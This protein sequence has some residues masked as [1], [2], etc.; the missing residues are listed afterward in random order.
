LKDSRNILPRQHRADVAGEACH[1]SR[2]RDFHRLDGVALQHLHHF[3]LEAADAILRGTNPG[4]IRMGPA[5][6]R[7]WV[8]SVDLA[9]GCKLPVCP[10]EPTCS[11]TASTEAMGQKATLFDHFVSADE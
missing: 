2:Q 11:G 3:Q 8:T 6:C 10:C 1:R 5:E 4:E 9:L 7:S